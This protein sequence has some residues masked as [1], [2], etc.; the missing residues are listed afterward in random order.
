MTKEKAAGLFLDLDG[1]LADS[2]AVIRAAYER[3]LGHFGKTG[4][5]AE[6]ARL[7]GPPLPAIVAALARSHGLADPPEQLTAIYRGLIAEAYRD[8]VPNAGAED[9]LQSARAAGFRIAVV[10]SN[11]A[12]LAR[13]WLD[14]AAFSEEVDCVVGGDEVHAGKPD[15]A[16]YLLALERT[17]C[18]AAKSLAVEDSPTGARA[19]TAAGLKTVLLSTDCTEPPSGVIV[20]DRLGDVIAHLG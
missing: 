14:R 1:T 15:P 2:L 10:T 7:N 20:V 11:G 4:S 17:G 18:V 8:V 5:D 19:A 9:L 16:P 12:A 13:A 3:F 6:F